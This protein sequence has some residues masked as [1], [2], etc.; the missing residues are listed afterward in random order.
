MPDS[1]RRSTQNLFKYKTRPIVYLVFYLQISAGCFLFRLSFTC[2]CDCKL[3]C[4]SILAVTNTILQHSCMTTNNFHYLKIINNRFVLVINGF[5]YF[6]QLLFFFF[7]FQVLCILRL[8]NALLLLRKPL[9]SL[10]IIAGYILHLF[11]FRSEHVYISCIF[12]LHPT[13]F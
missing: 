7:L 10:L 1:T 6:R 5:Y 12:F 2:D 8:I 3:Q 13:P 11:N 4:W 9:F